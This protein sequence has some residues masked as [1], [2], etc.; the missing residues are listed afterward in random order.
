M[1]AFL[2]EVPCQTKSNQ[3]ARLQEDQQNHA[4]DSNRPTIG[5]F[6]LRQIHATI[7]RRLVWDQLHQECVEIV[8]IFAKVW[9]GGLLLDDV[10]LL[11]DLL[12]LRL[13]LVV[14]HDPLVKLAFLLLH[15]LVEHH[16]LVALGDLRHGLEGGAVGGDHPLSALLLDEKFRRVVDVCLGE[17]G[18]ALQLH[19]QLALPHVPVPARL[20]QCS[21]HVSAQKCALIGPFA[22]IVEELLSSDL[23][24]IGLALAVSGESRRGLA[25]ESGELVEDGGLSDRGRLDFS[26]GNVRRSIGE[27]GLGGACSDRRR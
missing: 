6:P 15:H 13:K 7:I 18:L 2:P 12:L 22:D 9:R 11:L 14:G 16:A 10:V 17:E 21:F 25:G 3:T 27:R 26:G 20:E 5:V 24:G 1:P 8:V 4:G 19:L 23:A